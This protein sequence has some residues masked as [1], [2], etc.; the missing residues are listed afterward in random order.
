[1][2]ARSRMSM[3]AIL[4]APTSVTDDYGQPGA[5]SWATTG[6]PVACYAW[7]VMKKLAV[8]KGKTAL[9]EDFRA[10]VP[11]GTVINDEYRFLKIQDRRGRQIFPGPIL[12]ESIQIYADHLELALERADSG[13]NIDLRH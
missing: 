8:D 11:R 1:M 10:M 5:P 3:R 7:T 9:V 6:D 13:A 2:N 12:I 4:Q